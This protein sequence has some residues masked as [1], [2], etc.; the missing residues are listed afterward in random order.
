MLVDAKTDTMAELSLVVLPAALAVTFC[1]LPMFRKTFGG[2]IQV[3]VSK[4]INY[5]LLWKYP[6]SS[7]SSNR[8]LPT[9]CYQWPNGQGDVAK[10]LEGE[11]NSAQWGNK[12]GRVYRIWNGLTGEVVLRDP[13]DI[14]TVFK[15]SDKHV[16]AINNHAGWLMG[17]LLGQC[18]GLISGPRYK[19]L[20]SATN[21]AF[22]QTQASTYMDLIAT[23]VKNH[24]ETLAEGCLKR[25]RINPVADL[26]FLP[27]HIMACIIYGPL[28]QNLQHDLEGLIE[29]RESL[30]QRMMQGGI[31][32]YSWGRHLLPT[33]SKN[34][35]EFKRRWAKFNNDAQAHAAKLATTR[36][37]PILDWYDTVESGDIT[38]EE[39]LQTIDEMLFA[40]LDVTM[41]GLSWILLFL[42]ANPTVQGDIRHEMTGLFKEASNEEMN[43]YIQRSSTLLAASALESSRLKPLAAF[44]VPQ[45]APTDRV[46]GGYTMP[47]GTHFIVDTHALNVEN[48]Y[49]GFDSD[50]YRP[51]R[52]L[53]KKPSEMRYHF[54]RFG[55]GPRQCQGKHVVDLIIRCII[56]QLLENY[57]LELDDDTCWEKN[58]STWILHPNTEI[59]CWE[60]RT[61][62]RD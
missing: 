1:V 26:R 14:Q 6:I 22:T 20:R 21:A 12:Y 33:V 29:L 48:P 19:N 11:S 27:F 61:K 45:S 47:A 10:F 39:L 42:A 31:V 25:N 32:R 58:P 36:R 62:L 56:A 16:K 49:W 46:V 13:I 28:S 2:V 53:E 60:R 38:H 43:N 18:V 37:V 7:F 41:G 54:W 44:S 30:W 23:A 40:N 55:F 8:K 34:L 17:Q 57:D 52:F 24:F 5:Y 3:L 9:C 59:K 50:Q 15:D 4:T 35:V 51:S